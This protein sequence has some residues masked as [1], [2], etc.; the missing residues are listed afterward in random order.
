MIPEA[1]QVLDEWL[2]EEVQARLKVL[3]EREGP[4]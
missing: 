1:K 2:D 3:V 4:P